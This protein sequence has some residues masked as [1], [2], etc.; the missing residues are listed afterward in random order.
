MPEYDIVVAGHICLDLTPKFPGAVADS[1]ADVFMPGTLTVVGEC[2]VSTGGIVSNTGVALVKL[3]INAVLMGKVGDDAFGHIIVESLERHGC[4]EGIVMVPGE[5][6]SYSIV[7]S[8]PGFDRMFL[9]NAGAND[10]FCD[11]DIDYDALDGARMF[12]IGYP[13]LMARLYEADGAE[14]VEILRQAK[15]RG[16][17]TSLDMTLPDPSSPAGQVD[18]DAILRKALPW[19]D[20]FV[21]S[22]EEVL[23]CLEPE[24][25]LLLHE[26]AKREACTVLDLL[27]EHDY[28]RMGRRLLDYGVG[29]AMLKS[30]HRGIYVRSAGTGRLEAFGRARVCDAGNWA[31]RELWEPAFRPEHIASTTGAGDCAIAGFLAAFLNGEAIERS[32]RYAAA[33]GLQNLSEHDATSGLKSYEETTA[34][35]GGPEKAPLDIRSPEWRYNEGQRLWHGP[36][37]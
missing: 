28:E 1:L 26:R 23:D 34:M 17:T 31:D 36:A 9:H 8:A 35:L 25:F 7:I 2:V 12:H 29:V 4:A 22:A 5:H 27:S 19:V 11:D 24:V 37:R 21:P 18:W 33:V 3:G 32:L 14:L 15:D 30:G 20:L 13:Q 16:V 10:T 6:T